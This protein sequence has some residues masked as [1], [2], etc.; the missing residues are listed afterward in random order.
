MFLVWVESVC[1]VEETECFVKEPFA[2]FGVFFLAIVVWLIATTGEFVAIAHVHAEAKLFRFG[3]LDVE[4]SRL[5]SHDGS[6]FSVFYDY[7]MQAV[8][9]IAGLFLRIKHLCHLLEDAYDLFVSVNCCLTF[10]LSCFIC[11]QIIRIIQTTPM[12]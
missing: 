10:V 11:W 5:M 4:E 6:F 8:S 12:M 2:V 3:G 7:Q 9:N 1:L